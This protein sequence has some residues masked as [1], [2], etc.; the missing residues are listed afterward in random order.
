MKTWLVSDWHLGEDRFEIMQRPFT[1]VHQHVQ[2]LA[3]NHNAIVQPEDRVF[4][5]GDALYQKCADPS[6]FLDQIRH[7]NGRKTLIRGNHD[8]P[9]TDE[10]FAPYFEQIVPEGEGVELE[11]EGIQCYLT[12]YP[13]LGRND[14]F[15]LVGHIHGIWKMQLNS[16]NIG[17][18]VH[19]F[20]PT[21]AATIPFYHKAI[22]EF[23]DHDAWAGYQ[24]CN[25]EFRGKRGKQSTYFTPA[26]CS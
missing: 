12:H 13:T 1:D 8:R 9:F 26:T 4:V 17:V 7:F 10:Q 24:P 23:Y 22:C 2:V 11:I 18:D 5:V 16:L 3:Q 6:F 25:E 21:D 15:N 19:H 14:R 20:R